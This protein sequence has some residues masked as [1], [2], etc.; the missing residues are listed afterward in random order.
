METG[1]LKLCAHYVFYEGALSRRYRLTND[2]DDVHLQLII[3]MS[4]NCSRFNSCS[5]LIIQ[6]SSRFKLKKYLQQFCPILIRST[7]TLNFS[8]RLSDLVNLQ[9]EQTKA[10]TIFGLLGW[11]YHLLQDRNFK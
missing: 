1:I 3:E 4:L 11:A 6:N 10:C 7:L 9:K 5:E 2:F 8:V